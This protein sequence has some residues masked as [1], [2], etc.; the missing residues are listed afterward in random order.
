MFLLAALTKT[1]H[2]NVVIDY[3]VKGGPA[4]AGWTSYPPLSVIATQFRWAEALFHILRRH[5]A[6]IV[7]AARAEG[8]SAEALLSQALNELGQVFWY[9]DR[10]DLAAAAFG[11]AIRLGSVKYLAKWLAARTGSASLL[12]RIKQGTA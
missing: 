6:R 4:Q 10:M 12:R 8:T 3:F 11:D 2:P 9:A 1:A 5:R 7:A